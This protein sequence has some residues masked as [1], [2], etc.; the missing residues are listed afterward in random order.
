MNGA[1]LRSVGELLVDNDLIARRLLRDADEIDPRAA[2][3]AW[4]EVVESA[5][6][7]WAALPPPGPGREPAHQATIEQVDVLNRQMVRQSWRAGW[8]GNGGTD[9]QLREMAANFERA[10]ELVERGYE[11]REGVALSAPVAADVEASRLRIMHSLYLAAHAV[12]ATLGHEVKA[13]EDRGASRSWKHSPETVNGYRDRVVGVEHQLGWAVA[14]DW[15]SALAGEQPGPVDTSRL[16]QSWAAWELQ[17]HRSLALSPTTATLAAISATQV[18]AAVG[19]T[20]IVQAAAL[21]ERVDPAEYHDRVRPALEATAHHWHDA[22][23]TWQHLTP[24][25]DRSIDPALLHAARELRAS[26]IEIQRE[27]AVRATPEVMASRIDLGDATRTVHRAVIGSV[28]LARAAQDAITEAPLTGPAKSVQ[29]ATMAVAERAHADHIDDS[30]HA[31]WI[32]P[33][34]LQRNSLVPLPDILK[35]DLTKAMGEVIN[36]AV[37]ARDTAGSMRQAPPQELNPSGRRAEERQISTT[38]T[39]PPTITP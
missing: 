35:A 38:S 1:D 15:P 13:F 29:R 8:P 25:A 9:P 4:G 33:K 27:G 31:T 6:G 20:E 7:L 34:D 36:S 28:D 10:T 24:Q 12:G 30:P 19:G 32:S 22:A 17:A 5:T 3:R 21:L 14:R 37:T 23:R 11:Q 18:A 16:A 39:S 26:L 2:T